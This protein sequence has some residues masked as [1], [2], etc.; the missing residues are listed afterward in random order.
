MSQDCISA[1]PDVNSFR[2]QTEI[3]AFRPSAVTN[4]TSP[5]SS[6]TAKSAFQPQDSKNTSKGE[7]D[8]FTQLKLY[9]ISCNPH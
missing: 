7:H 4:T 1:L 5:L 6:N 9:Y 8:L 3:E 2:N